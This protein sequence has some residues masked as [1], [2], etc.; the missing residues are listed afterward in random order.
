MELTARIRAD[1][2]LIGDTPR[3]P[4]DPL[5]CLSELAA[6]PAPLNPSICDFTDNTEIRTA[7]NA[8]LSDAASSNAH[9][10]YL[11]MDEAICPDGLCRAVINGTISY[12]DSHH[13]TST[14]SE[15]QANVFLK[16][17]KKLDTST[18]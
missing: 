5:S 15:S 13:L 16:E 10:H 11:E 17:L 3:A 12:R 9:V 18:R 8:A 6:S 7:F 14:F 4:T 1:L 2:L